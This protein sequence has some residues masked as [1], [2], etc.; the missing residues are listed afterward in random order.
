MVREPTVE[1]LEVH[2]EG[3]HIVYYKEGH[4]NA[5]TIGK[6]RSTKPLAYFSANEQYQNALQIFCVDFPK[7]IRW[8][9]AARAWKPRAKYEIRNSP[10][11]QY[12]FPI[13]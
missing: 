3:H 7:Y 6:E 9:K 11:Q 1:R 12:D 2:L 4:E 8:D 10:P 13:P 5:K